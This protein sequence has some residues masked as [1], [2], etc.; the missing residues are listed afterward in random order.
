MFFVAC[1]LFGVRY[2][3]YILYTVGKKHVE[4]FYV[5]VYKMSN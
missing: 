1:V 2:V 4:V 5:C 3:G